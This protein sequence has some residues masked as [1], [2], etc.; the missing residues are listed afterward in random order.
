MVH[1][2]KIPDSSSFDDQILDRFSKVEQRL[3]LIHRYKKHFDQSPKINPEQQDFVN[4]FM[5]PTKMLV[6]VLRCELAIREAIEIAEAT[7]EVTRLHV[8]MRH[9]RARASIGR[10]WKS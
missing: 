6:F 8:L 7:A 4:G 3:D 2:S 5:R 9:S 10:P 1:A